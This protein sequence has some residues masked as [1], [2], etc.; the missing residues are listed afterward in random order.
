MF[1]LRDTEGEIGMGNTADDL[2]SNS[3]TMDIS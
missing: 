1:K 2:L 3:V